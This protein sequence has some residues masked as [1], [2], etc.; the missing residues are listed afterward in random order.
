VTTI[1]AD[2]L[3]TSPLASRLQAELGTRYTLQGTM[4]GGAMAYVF[5][6][7]ERALARRI[8]IKVLL[9][10]L[11]AAISLERFRREI[12]IS[13]SLQH[14]HIVPVLTAGETDGL[15]YF[16]M[17]Y[18]EGESLRT[19]LE[20]GTAIATIDGLRLLREVASALDCA[21]HRRII[22]RDIKP[23]NVLMSHGSAIVTDFGLAKAFYDGGVDE[24]RLTSQ[25]IALG[26]PAYMSPEQ[27]AASDSIDERADL[28][29]FGVLAY[30]LFTGAPTFGDRT[31]RELLAAHINEAPVPIWTLRPTLPAPLASLIMRCL[32]KEP[33]RRPRSAGDIVETLDSL[34]AERRAM[35]SVV[36]SSGAGRL[37]ALVAGAA[38]VRRWLGISG[39]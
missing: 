36:R 28:Y 15:P 30:E 35:A 4:P 22:H 9:P 14:P 17:P 29:S 24:K 11:A 5:V 38:G 39:G 26:T 16:M 8:V 13:A 19:R 6:A 20:R 27:A 31:P 21:H 18:V 7:W 32:E 33:H 3:S 23:G 2:F 12:T 34:S 10:Q 1:V 37:R 25:G